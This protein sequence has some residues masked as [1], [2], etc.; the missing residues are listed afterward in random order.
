[1]KRPDLRNYLEVAEQIANLH[2]LCERLKFERSDFP[3][4]DIEAAAL[5]DA[6]E[7]ADKAIAEI[8]YYS[9]NDIAVDQA[10]EASS[11]IEDAR[12]DIRGIEEVHAEAEK[13][14][15][16][17]QGE[18]ENIGNEIAHVTRCIA[19]DLAVKRHILAEGSREAVIGMLMA[20]QPEEWLSAVRAV[21]ESRPDLALELLLSK[22]RPRGI[23]VPREDWRRVY[24]CLL[25]KKPSALG[26]E[27]FGGLRK[28]DLAYWE[29]EDE[30]R[31]LDRIIQM[32][33]VYAHRLYKRGPLEKFSDLKSIVLR[34]FQALISHA[35]YMAYDMLTTRDISVTDVRGEDWVS[36]LRW[37]MGHTPGDVTKFLNS[38]PIPSDTILEPED[39]AKLLSSE[40]LDRE[41]REEVITRLTPYV[42]TTVQEQGKENVRRSR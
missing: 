24:E 33:P 41:Q 15:E 16:E 12:R 37:I 10:K 19:N 25:Q 18:I 40:M 26:Q 8:L 13:A 11:S 3:S 36:L 17:L 34:I 4:N 30:E 29:E 35:P 6:L 31:L 32:N 14:Y 2:Y 28:F 23:S 27:V 38:Y 1:M 7:S 9:E 22:H 20:E 39:L 42:R 5:F 21:T